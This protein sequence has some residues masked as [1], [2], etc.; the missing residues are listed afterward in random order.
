MSRRA[1]LILALVLSAAATSAA[2][3]QD[4]PALYTVTGVAADDVL[5]LRAEP[6]ADAEKVGMLAPDETN[7]EVVE[8]AAGDHWGR[9]NSGGASGWVS[10]QFMVNQGGPDWH[11]METPLSCHGTEPFW[12]L[13]LVPEPPKMRFERMGEPP[14]E[15]DRGATSPVFALPRTVGVKFAA[16][17]H[18]GFAV[19]RGEA[20]SDGMSDRL[21]GLSIQLFLFQ[22]GADEAYSGCCALAP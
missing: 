12:N 6:R 16:P 3:G 4:L 1:A 8:L 21:M 10:M 18:E 9:V 17:A 22:G 7:V 5:N 19:I 13:S 20:C 14:V 15:F 11:A 2:R